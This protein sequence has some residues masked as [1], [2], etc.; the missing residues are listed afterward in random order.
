MQRVIRRPACVVRR[1]R[2][3]VEGSRV[4][5]VDVVG[6]I[7]VGGRA[8]RM[9]GIAKGLLEAPDGTGSIVARTAALLRAEGV[10]PVLVGVHPEYAALALEVVADDPRARGPL[11]G[12]LALLRRAGAGHALAIACDMPFVT[13]ELVRRLRATEPDAAI[14]APRSWDEL[15][16]AALWEP[17][18]ARY[19]A[20][21]VLPH[22][23]RLATAGIG[24][25]Q[26]LLAEAGAVPLPVGAEEAT[27]LRDWD[28]S[29]DI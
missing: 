21:R 1:K 19:D 25:L 15:R 22:A 7:F 17:L 4:P 2:D 11:A 10:T 29:A 6:G 27:F 5:R 18:F 8:S 3:D 28:S 23:E 9:G 13:P 24:K 14:V 20:A 16:A 12:L 26:V